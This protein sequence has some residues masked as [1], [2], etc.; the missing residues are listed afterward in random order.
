MSDKS[1]DCAVLVVDVFDDNIVAQREEVDCNVDFGTVVLATTGTNPVVPS[2]LIG[3]IGCVI[4]N[5]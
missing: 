2:L 4:I 3:T 1:I 5:R